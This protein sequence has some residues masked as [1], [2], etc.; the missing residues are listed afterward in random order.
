VAAAREGYVAAFINLSVRAEDSRIADR[1]R[2]AYKQ[3]V[4]LSLDLLLP[5]LQSNAR[6]AQ[7][8][9]G[10]KWLSEDIAQSRTSDRSI[11]EEKTIEELLSAMLAR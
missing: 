7:D 10:L 11:S 3:G 4:Y 1:F 6:T 5:E 8:E 9:A 2:L